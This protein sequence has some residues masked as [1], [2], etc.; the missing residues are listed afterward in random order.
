MSFGFFMSPNGFKVE[1]VRL[2]LSRLARAFSGF[3]IAQISDIHMG[4]WMNLPRFQRVA[5]R[6]AERPL[7]FFPPTLLSSL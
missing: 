1:T 3:R 5:D 4:G 6:D 7:L 2:E